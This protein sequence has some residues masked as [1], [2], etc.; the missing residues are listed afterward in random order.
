MISV[1]P[2]H[3][4]TPSSANVRKRYT[5]GSNVMLRVHRAEKP[6]AGRRLSGASPCQLKSIWRSL[7]TSAGAPDGVRE[8]KYLPRQ[9]VMVTAGVLVAVGAGAAST[10]TWSQD[11]RLGSGPSRND[12][13]AA[14]RGG[15]SRRYGPGASDAT[16]L[17]DMSTVPPG[18]TLTGIA[19]AAGPRI[20]LPP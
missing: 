19:C 17:M 1:S 20:A 5:P 12:C 11:G 6:S 18:A 4:R 3:T 14:F 16:R 9:S 2:I 13:P 8:R 10:R 7:R 15:D